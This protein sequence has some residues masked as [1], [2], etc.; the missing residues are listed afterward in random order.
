M[1]VLAHR[2]PERGVGNSFPEPDL[3]VGAGVEAVGKGG[4]AGCLSRCLIA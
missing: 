4:S 1:K 3:G 2:L